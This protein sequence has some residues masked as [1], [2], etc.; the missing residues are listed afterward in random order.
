MGIGSGRV[1]RGGLQ[2]DPLR[3]PRLLQVVRATHSRTHAHTHARTHARTHAQVRTVNARSRP[4]ACGRR[5]A[6]AG[7]AEERYLCGEQRRNRRADGSP[8]PVVQAG[9]C[10][11]GRRPAPRRDARPI[12]GGNPATLCA[13]RASASGPSGPS[14][15]R[16][17]L[18]LS[19]SPRSRAV[20]TRSNVR[21]TQ[22]ESMHASAIRIHTR[23][24]AQHKQPSPPQRCPMENQPTA[25][26]LETIRPN[27]GL[28]SRTRQLVRSL[29]S[30]CR[31]RRCMRR[32][33]DS[34]ER[35]NAPSATAGTRPKHL[36]RHATVWHSASSLSRTELEFRRAHRRCVATGIWRAGA[37]GEQVNQAAG[38]LIRS[39]GDYGALVLLDEAFSR[40][41]AM[42]SSWC[43]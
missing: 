29:S 36:R 7:G 38:R 21:S 11:T 40:N 23:I 6:R 12:C 30:V 17:F 26:E 22:S 15:A 41:T 4:L 18:P 24:R 8:C 20:H 3:R 42:L 19:A 5:V 16:H 1:R 10:G 33:S 39:S 31:I 34:S 14:Y 25:L 27:R 37:R 9:G 28:T 35:M 13:C 32:P 43:R 2:G